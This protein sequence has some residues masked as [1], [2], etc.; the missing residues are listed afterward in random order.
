[1][2]QRLDSTLVKAGAVPSLDEARKLIRTGKVMVCK[3]EKKVQWFK[4]GDRLLS[5]PRREEC[6]T[7]KQPH[8]QPGDFFYVRSHRYDHRNNQYTLNGKKR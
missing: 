1:M 2:S 6:K 7:A 3:R 5:P 8:Q 4:I